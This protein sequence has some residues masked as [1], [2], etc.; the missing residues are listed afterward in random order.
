MSIN[1]RYIGA[2]IIAPFFI[3]IF[4]GGVYLKYFT[5]ILSL[6]GM[7]EFYKVSKESGLK[8][9][10]YVGYVILLCFFASN[11][12]FESLSFI[13]IIATFLLLCA[14]VLDTKYTYVDMAVTILGFLYVGVFFS[15]IYLISQ[16]DGGKYLVWL[17]FISSWMCDTTAYYSGRF[18]GKHKLN[19]E[20]S[21]KKTIEGSIGGLLGSTVFCGIY[22]YVV[23]NVFGFNSILLYHYIIIGALCGIF[24]Q[25]GDL[26]ASSVKRHA[27]VKDYSNLIPGHGGILDRF[28]SIIYSAVL[29]FFY[30][31]L[32]Q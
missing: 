25:F 12:N 2:A 29:I 5:L 28:D 4:L 3:F 17:I 30:L 13:L 24:S 22:G 10:D 11:Y 20:V 32:I 19:P 15:C 18:F 7:Y 16:F 31:T 6:L 9:M 27:G 8:T 23:I 14:P 21:A 1:K 26:V